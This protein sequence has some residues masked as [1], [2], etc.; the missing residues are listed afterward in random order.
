MKLAKSLGQNHWG[1][2]TGAKSLGQ[3]HWGKSLG[4]NHWGRPLASFRQ[5]RESAALAL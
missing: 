3:N 5:R 1:K 2:I 4:Q